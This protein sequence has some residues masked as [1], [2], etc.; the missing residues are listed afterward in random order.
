MY[1]DFSQPAPTG[2]IPANSVPPQATSDEVLIARI[3]AGD[4]CY[5][6][7]RRYLKRTVEEPFAV[8]LPG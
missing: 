2:V 4:P 1:V 5:E 3:A 8:F 7:Y 6:S